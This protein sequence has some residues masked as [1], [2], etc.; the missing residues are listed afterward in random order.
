MPQTQTSPTVTDRPPASPQSAPRANRY[1][2]KIEEYAALAGITINGDAP[3]DPQVHDERL[4]QRIFSRGKL[5]LGE[6][7]MEGWWDCDRLDEL[8]CRVT[9]ADLARVVRR[10][11]RTLLLHL[12]SR[13]FNR[14]N[15]RGAREV[16]D[17]HYNSGNDH[18][19]KMLGPAL[20]YSC[21]YFK[22]TDDLDQAQEAKLDLICRK[23]QLQPTDRVLD[24]GFGWGTFTRYAARKYGCQIVG[25]SPSEEQLKFCQAR[26]GDLPIQ[27]VLSDYREPHKYNPENKPFDKIVSIGMFEHVGYKNYRDYFQTAFDQ[28]KPGGLFVLHTFGENADEP[29]PDPWGHKYI[30]PNGMAPSIKQIGIGVADLFVMEDWQN[31]GYY[32]YMTYMKW[33]ENLDA[34]NPDTRDPFYRMWRY[35]LMYFGGNF[36]SRQNVQLWQ[37]VLS[38]GGVD[39]VY[40]APR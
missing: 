10:D 12:S 5:G 11:W 9:K 33:L 15:I 39:G 19:E 18:F 35:F 17:V 32:Y 31:M 29:D 27:Y 4:Y 36:K 14:Q 7:Y 3:W 20:A 22:D 2:R 24:I 28:L 1:R 26:D 34:H 25:V 37:I 40:H 30:Y 38:K 8:F 23:L 13:L 6:A 21:A 16:I